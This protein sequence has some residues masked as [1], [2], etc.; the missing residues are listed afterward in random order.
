MHHRR[1]RRAGL[2]RDWLADRQGGDAAEFVGLEPQQAI[3]AIEDGRALLH[4]AGI[5]PRGF[6]APAYAYTCVLRRELRRSFDW[7]GGL[8]AI[9]GPRPV[10]ALANGLGSSTAFKRRASP[11]VLRVGAR[12]PT[13]VLR[14]DVHPADFELPDH[15][16]AL[17]TLLRRSSSSRQ[18]ATYDELTG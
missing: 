11:A 15:V 17:D 10:L 5:S 7:Y 18:P 13:K 2:A 4:A 1:S 9:H 16:G 3:A 6:V 8:V 14:V 12:L